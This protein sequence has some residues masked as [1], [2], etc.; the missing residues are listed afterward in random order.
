MSY[1]GIYVS[2]KF[3]KSHFF[4]GGGGINILILEISSRLLDSTDI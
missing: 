2:S 3:V 1:K 4:F